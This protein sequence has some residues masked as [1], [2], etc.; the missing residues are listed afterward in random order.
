MSGK[1]I[2]KG[3]AVLLAAALCV[4]FARGS[5]SMKTGNESR[6]NQIFLQSDRDV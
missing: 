2:K 3:I 5:D 6:R 4:T 1:I